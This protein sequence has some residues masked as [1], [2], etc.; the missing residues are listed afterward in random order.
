[1]SILSFPVPL[2][3]LGVVCVRKCAK[4]RLPLFWQACDRSEPIL[5]RA[6]IY[7]THILMRYKQHAS[8]YDIRDGSSLQVLE[9]FAYTILLL[10]LL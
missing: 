5:R 2:S 3:Q 9:L 1:M 8:R 7:F 6:E 10:A 4:R